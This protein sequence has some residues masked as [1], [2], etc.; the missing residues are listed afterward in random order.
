MNDEW[1]YVIH[2]IHR[3][4][5]FRIPE[6]AAIL[7]VNGVDESY[8][9]LLTIAPSQ[10]FLVT[11]LPGDEIARLLATRCIL[12]RAVYQ[13]IASGTTYEQVQED[14]NSKQEQLKQYKDCSWCLNVEIFEKSLS[15]EEQQLKRNKVSHLLPFDGP[16]QLKEP[17]QVFA[18]LEYERF[19]YFGRE[20]QPSQL[21]AR[22]LIHQYS[23]KARRYIGPTSMDT[24]LA[25][26]MA[27][28][29]MCNPNALV[30]DPF[31][32][33]GGCLLA[34]SS[35]GAQCFGTDIDPIALEKD[36]VASIFNNFQQYQLRRP[37]IICCDMSKP[38]VL[39]QMEWDAIVCDPPYGL[40]AG[41]KKC[42][43]GPSNGT[44]RTSNYRMQHVITD[45]LQFAADHLRLEGRLVYV[46]P[47]N[48]QMFDK[49]TDLPTHTAL[50]I[51]FVGTERITASLSRLFIVMEK[52][53][54]SEPCAPA[55]TSDTLGWV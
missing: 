41:A 55:S 38:P 33:T 48:T 49:D 13:L 32:G 35:F 44:V 3:Y 5:E 28:L 30:L 11:Q 40:R 12:I 36:K 51:I 43:S 1:L 54:S 53:K 16:V 25:L 4:M 39:Q 31:V 14:I 15:R 20:I 50:R 29:A 52:F 37:E 19:I 2:F 27:N 7:K 24:E 18:V 45:L 23:I 17:D 47:I 42:A 22:H 6:V 34:C 8:Y 26:I 10:V 46:L 9:K 21:K